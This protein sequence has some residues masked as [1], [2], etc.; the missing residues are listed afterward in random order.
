[1]QAGRH[2]VRSEMRHAE[3]DRPL[4]VLPD[5]ACILVRE[6]DLFVEIGRIAGFRDIFE[7]ICLFISLTISLNHSI[8]SSFV[9]IVSLLA[10]LSSI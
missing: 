1:M 5:R 3:I 10:M 8:A 4:Q 9:P 7:N 6:G 2:A